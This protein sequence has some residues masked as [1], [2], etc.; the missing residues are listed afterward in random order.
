MYVTI[1][2][3]AGM[4]KKHIKKKFGQKTKREEKLGHR[5]IA[6]RLILN[7]C[8]TETHWEGTD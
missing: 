2:T 3:L 1:I 5:E 4:D 6:R 8:I 7:L